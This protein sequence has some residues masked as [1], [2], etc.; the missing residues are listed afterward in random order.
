[1]SNFEERLLREL[2]SLVVAQPVDRGQRHAFWRGRRLV[3]AGGLAAVLAA[4]ATA[5]VF[6]LSAGTQAAYAV[7]KNADGTVT[8]EID[9]LS[10]AAGLQAKLQAAGLNAVVQYLPAGKACKQPWFT[11]A[12]VGAAGGTRGSEVGRTSDGTTRFTI[13]GNVPSSTTLMITTQTGP[14]DERA[15]GIAWAKGDVPPCEVVAAP[16]GSGPLGG[17]PVDG[18]AQSG[19]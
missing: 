3:L 17:P 19:P 16:A 12:G 18:S 9:S 1:M 2:Q 7:T 15:L 5:G 8:V 11:P 4:A 14:G 6:F 13:S 10:D